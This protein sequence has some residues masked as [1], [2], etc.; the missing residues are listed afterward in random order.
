LA[1]WALPLKE[2]KA[3]PV[4]AITLLLAALLLLLTMSA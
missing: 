4:D 1:R 3:K 2:M